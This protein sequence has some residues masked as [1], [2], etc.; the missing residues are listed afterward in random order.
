MLHG[1]RTDIFDVCVWVCGWVG[2][3]AVF[4]SVLNLVSCGYTGGAGDNVK[5]AQIK[6][7]LF[8]W[9]EVENIFGRQ[10]V[11]TVFS[12]CLHLWAEA[13]RQLPPALHHIT[14]FQLGSCVP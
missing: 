6:T 13:F 2:G 5:V 1:F 4:L 7:E 9:V 10:L 3:G 11:L 14:F 8:K 12:T